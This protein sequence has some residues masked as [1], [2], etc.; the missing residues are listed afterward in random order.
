MM[1]GRS[2]FD[3]TFD[4]RSMFDEAE[5]GLLPSL[6]MSPTACGSPSSS[7]EGSGFGDGDGSQKKANSSLSKNNSATGISGAA[8]FKNDVSLLENCTF[9]TNNSG[10]DGGALTCEGGELTMNDC[11]FTSNTSNR[12]E[13]GRAHV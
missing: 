9:R 11:Q 6:A 7:S 2:R 1:F 4:H 13:I 5:E 8:A 3:R 10:L 12:D